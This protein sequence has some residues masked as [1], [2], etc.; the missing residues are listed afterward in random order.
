MRKM[1]GIFTVLLFLGSL[2]FVFP[3]EAPAADVIPMKIALS[4]KPGSPRVKGAE[5]FAKLIHERTG[6]RV[7]AKVFPNSQLGN[8]RQTIE[9]LQMG[10]LECTIMPTAFFGGFNR[11][12]TIVD[13]PFLFPSVEAYY[14]VMTGPFGKELAKE[15]ETIRLK[16]LAFWT[17]GWKQFTSNFPIR[18]PGDFKGYKVRVMPSPPLMEQYR[19][20]GASPIPIEFPELYNALQL[21]TVD[22][23]ENMLY[24]NEE[25]KFYEVQKYITISNHALMPEI[26]IVGKPWFDKLPKDIQEKMAATFQEIAP[27]EAKWIDEVDGASVAVFKKHGNVVYTLTPAE[28]EEF[29]KL[30]PPVW[31]K[32][33]ETYK[34]KS[35]HYL[36]SLKK[37]IAAAEKPAM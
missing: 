31:E 26:V 20:Y 21:G 29:R 15:T 27:I 2:V 4:N 34:G 18:K 28:R 3:P 17:A 11:V 24:R 7:Q 1:A 10:S 32:F 5:L 19:S 25:M 13:L 14:K 22:A 9:Q 16:T 33:V 30:A 37:S 35:R 12:L 8:T 36:D 6:G 23:Q